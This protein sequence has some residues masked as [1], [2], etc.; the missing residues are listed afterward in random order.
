MHVWML[1]TK[2]LCVRV[3]TNIIQCTLFMGRF[4]CERMKL[5]P[6]LWIRC[7]SL[8]C[9]DNAWII[10][11]W[12][13]FI[14]TVGLHWLIKL[15]NSTILLDTMNSSK[16]NDSKFSKVLKR[17]TVVTWRIVQ[18]C[19]RKLIV[20]VCNEQ[21]LCIFSVYFLITTRCA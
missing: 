1:C 16:I 2:W 4:R 14:F 3:D 21:S 17:Q 10:R 11:S 12:R 19:L 8:D 9:E 20:I 7:S 5:A 18:I 15:H 13:K 6:I